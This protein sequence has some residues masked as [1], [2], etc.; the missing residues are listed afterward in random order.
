M[1]TLL[2]REVC[3]RGQ[4]LWGEN[5]GFGLRSV[6]EPAFITEVP[7][8]SLGLADTRPLLSAFIAG[9]ETQDGW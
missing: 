4:E 6:L 1:Q 5:Q 8:P 7:I 9:P 3:H 2:E